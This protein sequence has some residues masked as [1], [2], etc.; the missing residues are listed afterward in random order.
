MKPSEKKTTQILIN[1]VL[2]VVTA[3]Q[4][5][6]IILMIMNS[7][8]S[9]KEIKNNPLAMPSSFMPENFVETWKKGEYG[10]AFRNSFF[11]GIVTILLV[12]LTA[13]LCG[14]ALSR[15]KVPFK[16]FFTGYF[17]MAMSF[18]AF[19]Y[20]V[21]RYFGFSELGLVNNH[22]GLIMIYCAIYAPFSVLLIRTFLVEI[23]KELEEAAKVDGCGELGVLL[24]IIIP[25]AKPIIMTVALIIFTWTWNEFMWS[26]TFVVTESLRTVSTRFYKFTSKYSM[27]LAKIYTSGVIT[28]GPIIVVYLFLQKSF[29][30]GLT[31]GSVKG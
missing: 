14:Y 30:E 15:L 20:I 28:T 10:I 24:Y 1:L 19:L 21:P 8:R 12:L 25:L 18:P 2:L 7:F 6:P 4:I 5:F 22:T 31:A 11:I 3:F 16:S 9:D 27:D 26:N 17:T 23:P 29:V 13:G